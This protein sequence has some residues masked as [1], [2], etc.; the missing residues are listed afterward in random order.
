MWV[1]SKSGFYSVVQTTDGKVQV[2][3]RSREDLERLQQF[4]PEPRAGKILSTPHADY[5][6]RIVVMPSV[7]QYCVSKLAEEID[8]P[9]FKD[10][11]AAIDQDRAQV[12]SDVWGTLRAIE[13]DARRPRLRRDDVDDAFG[14]LPRR[15]P[16]R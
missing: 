10:A 16:R 5:P 1:I 3:S 6:Y 4:M 15:T 8:Y 13:L 7:W 11:V 12:Y 14:V 2:R 9:N